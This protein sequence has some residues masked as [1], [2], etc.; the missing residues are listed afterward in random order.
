MLRTFAAGR[1]FGSRS[2]EGEP[3]V[4]AL[5]GWAR[6]HRDFDAVLRPL[7]APELAAIAV[8]LPGF[9][10]TSPPVE[11]WGSADYAHCVSAVLGEMAGPAVV[12]AHSFGGRVALHLAA[13]RPDAVRALVLTGVPLLRATPPRRP[14]LAYRA[15]RSRHRAGL[16]GEERMERARRRYGS[17]DYAAATGVMRQ[18]HGRVVVES[19]EAQLDALDCPVTLVWGDDDATAPLSIARAALERLGRPP[20]GIAADLVVVTG[21]G[22]L[23]PLAAPGAL[24]AAVERHLG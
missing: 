22:H 7:G 6:T 4:L 21:V 9:G 16:V 5:H 2:G 15:V 20:N 1:L 3:T 18:V 19:Y 10:M 17:A 8:D 14:R 23:L 11:P 24:R 13:S 12:V